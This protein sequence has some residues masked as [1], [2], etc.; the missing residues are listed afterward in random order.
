MFI[1]YRIVYIQDLLEVYYS[2]PK[3]CQKPAETTRL[4]TY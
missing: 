1:V 3:M 4:R 2:A